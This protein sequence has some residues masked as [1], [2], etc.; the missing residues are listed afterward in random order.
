MISAVL[1]AWFNMYADRKLVRFFATRQRLWDEF[2]AKR[3]MR[4]TA[5]DGEWYEPK[6]LENRCDDNVAPN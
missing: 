1:G 4:A 2:H 6:A 5:I 3:M